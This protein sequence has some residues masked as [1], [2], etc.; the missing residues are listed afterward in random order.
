MPSRSIPRKYAEAL[1]LLAEKAGEPEAIL[2]DMKSLVGLL[3]QMPML[4]SFL[5][6]PDVAQQEKLKF[7]EDSLRDRVEQTTWLFL[8]L[9][10]N[11]KRMALL[12]EILSEYVG[13]DEERKGIQRAEV[14]SA[15]SLEEG[16][17]KLLTSTLRDITGKEI[18]IESR[19]DP[20][21]VGGMIVYLNGKVI[22]GSIR[23][24]LVELRDQLSAKPAD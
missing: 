11:R 3:R 22:D 10:L 12:P 20:S 17:R 21:I 4:L 18:M 16:E 2:D 23:N 6:S 19:V 15:V 8:T 9:L 5:E 7:L 14:V 24:R 13:I 1:F